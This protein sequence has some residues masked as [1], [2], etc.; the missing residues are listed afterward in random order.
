MDTQRCGYRL[1]GVGVPFGLGLGR[2]VYGGRSGGAHVI[3]P[4]NGSGLILP[5]SQKLTEEYFGD[6]EY[7]R[8]LA[9]IEIE[10][11]FICLDLPEFEDL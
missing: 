2:S 5:A 11:Q 9:E 10:D 4:A 7:E 3:V 1:H 8:R 6:G